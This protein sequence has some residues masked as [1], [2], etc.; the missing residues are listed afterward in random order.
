MELRG[1]LRSMVLRPQTRHERIHVHCQRL[2]A[3]QRSLE[4]VVER[5]ANLVDIAR[6]AAAERGRVC[7]SLRRIDGFANLLDV[8]GLHGE[9]LLTQLSAE[10]NLP[11]TSRDCAP[12]LVRPVFRSGGARAVIE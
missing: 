12:A 11:A 7:K 3:R 8:S 2:R 5:L 9:R 4:L 1:D 10:F 6:I